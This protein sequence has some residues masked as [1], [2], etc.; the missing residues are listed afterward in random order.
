VEYDT[1]H[2]RDLLM[3]KFFLNRTK[4]IRLNQSKKLLQNGHS[5][6]AGD[7]SEGS[8]NGATRLGILCSFYR[9]Q[10]SFELEP[11]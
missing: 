4:S 8:A 1:R 5:N 3:G 10:S 9:L 6:I 2:V 7:A 11:R